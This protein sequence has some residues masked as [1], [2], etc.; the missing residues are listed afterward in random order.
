VRLHFRAAR[1]SFLNADFLD[2]RTLRDVFI[3]ANAPLSGRLRPPTLIA[4]ILAASTL[5]ALR[6]R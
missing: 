6:N 1:R 4:C 5:N 2:T 3:A